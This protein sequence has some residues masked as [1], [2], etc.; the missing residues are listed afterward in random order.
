M[1]ES[2]LVTHIRTSTLLIRLGE[3]V[4]VTDPWFSMRMRFLPALVRPGIPLAA[5]PAPHLLLCSH[6]HADHFEPA[7]IRKLAAAHTVIVGP[8]G[9]GRRLRSGTAGRVEEMEGGDR[10]DV[11]GLTVTAFRVPHTF[12]PPE[13]I[14]Y[15]V[16]GGELAFFFG[17]DGAYD[18]T[19][20]RMGAAHKVDVAL[21]PVGGSVILGR[22][23]VMDPEEALTAATE[24]G[25]SVLIPIHQG[26]DWPALPPISCHPGRAE[27][28][29]RLAKERKLPL[30]VVAPLPGRSVLISRPFRGGA[31]KAEVV[32]M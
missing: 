28:A 27:D 23:T 26:G 20:R 7:A 5:I 14:G 10:L 32:R 12:P 18:E 8:L 9:T 24:M 16:A 21:L 13:E 29:V 22:R 2:L 4:I 6:L 15:R 25:A 30:T 3:R 11:H 19:Y 31:I 17:G 1:T